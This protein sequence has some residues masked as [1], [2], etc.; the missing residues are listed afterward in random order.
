MRLNVLLF[1]NHRR[2]EKNVYS[3]NILLLL[4]AF[5]R[6]GTIAFCRLDKGCRNTT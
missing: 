3:T 5:D 2:K 4:R 1:K 6:H